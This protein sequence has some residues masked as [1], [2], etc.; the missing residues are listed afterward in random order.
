M[1]YNPFL[2]K[3]FSEACH[4]IETRP[5]QMFYRRFPAFSEQLLCRTSVNAEAAT[6][7]ALEKKVLK[8]FAI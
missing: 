6:G 7:G 1:Q 8:C 5:H 4:F 2:V 3:T